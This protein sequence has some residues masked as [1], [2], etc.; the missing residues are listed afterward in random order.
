MT[1]A[2]GAT[3]D[4]AE[5]SASGSA[6]W[7]NCPGSHALCKNAPP[8]PESK[9][10][11]EG[12]EAHACFEFMVKN[13][14]KPD[15][16]L[17]KAGL[18]K[19]NAEMVDHAIAALAWIMDRYAS[20]LMRGPVTLLCETKVDASPF[21]CTGQFG[22]LDAAIVEEFGRLVVIDYKYGA[23]VGVDPVD[24]YGALNSQLAYYAL[25]VSHMYDHDFAEAELVIIQPRAYHESGETIR[26]VVVPMPELLAWIPR[27]RDGVMATGDP[28]APLKAGKWCKF[29]PAAISCPEVKNKALREA[30][31]V[32]DDEK[33]LESVPVPNMIQLP[34]LGTILSACDKLEAWIE[35]VREHAHNV[36]EN[37]GAVPGFK[38]VQKRGQRKWMDEDITA[39]EARKRFGD[40]AFS[41][42]KILSPAQFEK[43]TKGVAGAD[44]WAAKRTETVSS[45]TTI[46]PERDKRPAVN[47]AKT[48]AGVFKSAGSVVK[49][50][51]ATAASKRRSK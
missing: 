22:T 5:F 46:A 16:M 35:K 30:Q 29:C 31:V 42:P 11:L 9:Y 13:A 39:A 50:L 34:H 12:T 18:K 49:A 14:G 25:G 17:R 27:F 51:P 7:M 33:G 19:W 32:F 24:E 20:A 36:L 41:E 21:T 38:L 47:S 37:G 2:V 15:A 6:R 3:K 23:G 26:S 10:A 4:H 40:V 1:K 48:A 8:A 45:G 44:D 28:K 43:A